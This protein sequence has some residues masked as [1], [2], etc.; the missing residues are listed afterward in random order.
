MDVW[1]TA[2]I[3]CESDFDCGMRLYDKNLK[4]LKRNAAH[5]VKVLKDEGFEQIQVKIE[6]EGG[7]W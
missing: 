7:I 4:R 6:K 3:T 2:T 1:Y 5:H